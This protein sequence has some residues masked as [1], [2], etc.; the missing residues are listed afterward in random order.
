MAI[1]YSGRIAPMSSDRPEQPIGTCAT[2]FPIRARYLRARD[3]ASDERQAYVCSVFDDLVCFPFS[4]E[5]TFALSRADEDND[6][7]MLDAADPARMARYLRVNRA[8]L[9]NVAKFAIMQDSSPPRRARMLTAG[10]DDVFDST[11]VS[12]EEARLRVA[13]VI[14]RYHARWATRNK[15]QGIAADMAQFAA[16]NTLTPR[17]LALL[18]A[19]AEQRGKSMSV[20]RL[21]RFVAPPD[22]AQFR[23]SL[24]F[25]ISRLRRKL[26]PQWRIESAPDKGYALLRFNA[27]NAEPKAGSEASSWRLLGFQLGLQDTEASTHDQARSA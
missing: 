19:L 10:C 24:K 8:L 6:V 7:L 9:R 23:R 13:A 20:Q 11:R 1:R 27:G 25:S 2:P 12:S 4:D 17:E 5:G 18:S 22:T 21:S 14:R 16:P 3:Q 15:D 26:Y